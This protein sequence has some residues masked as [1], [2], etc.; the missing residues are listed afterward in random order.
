[1]NVYV[2]IDETICFYESDRNYPDAQPSH[3]NIAKI[4]KLYDEGHTIVF[5]TARGLASG[6]GEQHY[7]PITEQQLKEW[8]VKYHE[9]CFKGH[10]GDYFIDDRGINAKDFF[11]DT[12]IS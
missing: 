1:M 5:F 11:N 2:D 12:D 10:N 7:R 3:K 4:N 8:G 9:L 6:R